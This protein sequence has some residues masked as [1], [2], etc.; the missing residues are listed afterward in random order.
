MSTFFPVQQ[1]GIGLPRVGLNVWLADLTY[2]QQSISSEI[3]PQAVGGIAT[4]V[5]TQMRLA[6]PV[7]IFKYPEALARALREEPP[8]DVLGFSNYVWN[9]RLSLAMAARVKQR[10][11]H[12][13][14]V[15]G[16][17]HYPADQAEQEAFL[18]DN[19]GSAVD[20]YVDREGEQALA[21]LLLEL[22][23]ADGEVEAVH[24]KVP[25]VHS[26]DAHDQAHLPPPEPRLRTLAEVP[27]PYTTGLM[28][29]FFDGRLIPVVQTNRGCP[30]S[31][32]FC[33]EGTRYYSKVAKKATDPMRAELLYI[34]DKMKELIKTAGVRNE[35]LITD[36]NFGMYAEDLE[37]CDI[38]AE[39]QDTYGWPRYVNLTTGKNKRDR[40]LEAIG[41]TRGTMDLSGS[42]Q[43]LDPEVLKIIRRNNIDAGA[44]MEVALAAAEQRTGTYSEVILGLPGDSK[45]AHFS[46]LSQLI[47][48]H[49]DRLNMFQLALLPGS[50]LWTGNQRHEHGMKTRFRVIPRCYGQYEVLGGTVTAAEIDEICMELPSM[51]F[52]DYL[53]CRQMNL[54]ISACYNEGTLAALVKLLRLCGVSV[55]SWV[56]R[57]QQLPFGEDVRKVVDEFR[58]ET[59]G[60]LWN[61]RE[62]LATYAGD[63]VQ[64]FISGELGNNLLYTYRVRMLT[65]ALDD[66]VDLAKQAAHELCSE[67]VDESDVAITDSFI[68]EAGEYHRLRMVNLLDPRAEVPHFQTATFDVERFVEAPGPLTEF[69][70][71]DRRVRRYTLSAA[72]ASLIEGYLKQFGSAA[73]GAGRM[74]TRIRINDLLR[75][76]ELVSADDDRQFVSYDPVN[77]VI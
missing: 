43:S 74:L 42:V 36:S 68:A 35:L 77:H 11:P 6:H 63:N 34:G 28:D 64:R 37:V 60:Q 18:R 46:T 8:P 4:Y 52:G 53:D 44:L 31:C 2:T 25:G 69:R 7:R 22:H 51:S 55:F 73:W 23:K 67:A 59:Q 26:I 15:F 41:R 70:I 40:V 39:C 27:S 12:V 1:L 5:A 57:M 45:R 3:M 29:E 75:Q 14:T 61:S 54:F 50:D 62:E 24:G 16:G 9:S 19:L 56:Q 21:K 47:E 66:I 58:A 49:F 76:V 13:I 17:P 20:F 10:L 30:F 32:S 38:I 72:Q 33:V 65:E 48:A 71:A